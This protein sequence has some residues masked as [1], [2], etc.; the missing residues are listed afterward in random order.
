MS[1]SISPT[2]IQIGGIH[3]Y[4]T[5]EEVLNKMS[6]LKKINSSDSFQHQFVDLGGEGEPM[7]RFSSEVEDVDHE[8]MVIIQRRDEEGE[9][10]SSVQLY[11]DF[12]YESLTT[13]SATLDEI[14]DVVGS[15]TIEHL[16]I[17]YEID[18][19]FSNLRM[20]TDV[21]DILDYEL[22]GL[23]VADGEFTYIIQKADEE[24]GVAATLDEEPKISADS[25]EGFIKDEV[26]AATRFV[27]EVCNE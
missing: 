15:F 7:V 17:T 16:Y 5:N 26:D 22:R 9:E 23:R 1:S 27:E 4:D 24:I 8:E 20:T 21:D 13:F 18:Q 25:N 11:L 10:S 14:L 3:Q 19:D 12:P 6:E 2:E